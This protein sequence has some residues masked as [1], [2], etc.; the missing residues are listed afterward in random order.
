MAAPVSALAR[1]LPV[2][3]GRARRP[4]CRGR[5]G[6]RAWAGRPARA[7]PW[8]GGW[9][10]HFE[11]AVDDR[12]AAAV[13]RLGDRGVGATRPAPCRSARRTGRPGRRPRGRPR[14]AARRC[15]WWRPSAHTPQVLDLGRPA[16][17]EQHADEVDPDPVGRA[18][19]GPATQRTASRRSRSPLAGPTASSG[20]PYAAELRVFTSQNTSTSPS[21]RTRSI[22][23]SVA[24]PVAVDEHHARRRRAAGPRRARRTRRGCC[25]V[26]S[27]S[28]DRSTP[29]AGDS[30]SSLEVPPVDR[31]ACD[32]ELW[33]SNGHLIRRTGSPMTV[34]SHVVTSCTA[35]AAEADVAR[36]TSSRPGSRS[37]R[38][39]R[40]GS[41]W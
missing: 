39:S 12:G 15:A 8:C 41:G 25:C 1:E 21:R 33:T 6:G 22:S 5:S 34:A 14:P 10:G 18:R 20:W 3:G 26:D 23:P 19:R 32:G 9:L 40:R 30:G 17:G 13:A 27:A 7:A 29:S 24:P 36:G 2:G 28:C 31:A 38:C 37:C 11:A 16:L 35:A 4:R